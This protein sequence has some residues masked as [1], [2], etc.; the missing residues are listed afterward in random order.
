MR[1]PVTAP[2][3]VLDQRQDL[4]DLAGRHYRTAAMY[5]DLT[6]GLPAAAT[7]R[8]HRLAGLHFGN[9]RVILRMLLEE[10]SVS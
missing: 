9:C 4:R 8:A 7:G 10:G 3:D 1:A 5:E 6:H 2:H